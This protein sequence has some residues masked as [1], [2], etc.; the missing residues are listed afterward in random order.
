EPT[1]IGR[2]AV[3]EGSIRVIGPIHVD[4]RIEGTLIAE[5]EASIGSTGSVLGDVMV[6]ALMLDGSIDGNVSVRGHLHVASGGRANGEVRYGSLQ[7]DRGGVLAGS[8]QHGEETIMIE[9][10]ACEEVSEPPP[11]PLRALDS[12]KAEREVPVVAE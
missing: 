1:V 11:P 5:R 12:L 3:I 8:A 7:V 4:G 2:D 9:A 10:E 6:E